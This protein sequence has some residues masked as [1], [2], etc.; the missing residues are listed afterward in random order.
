MCTVSVKVDEAVLREIMPELDSNMAIHLWVQKLV[1]EH[2]QQLRK[3]PQSD[4]IPDDVCREI[5][6]EVEEENKDVVS[7][8]EET[9]DLET[10]RADL[11]QM[12]EE[13][14]AEP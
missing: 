13:V 5:W 4:L 1:D 9:I 14:Y 2:V 6:Q 7:D 3:M 8:E 10:F 11:H 12:I